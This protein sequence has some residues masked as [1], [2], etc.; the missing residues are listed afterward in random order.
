MAQN[1]EIKLL[2]DEVGQY[3]LHLKCE[4]C[5][6]ER[7]ASPHTLA[8]LC[9]W[10]CAAGRRGAADALFDLWEEKVYGARGAADDAE[11]VQ[12]SLRMRLI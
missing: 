4:S 8:K 3:E 6:H 10:G 5:L 2:R 12:E 11:R 9:G 1:R 7:P